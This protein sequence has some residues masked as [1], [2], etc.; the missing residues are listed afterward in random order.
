[1]LGHDIGHTPFG[2]SGE[3]AMDELM[4]AHGGFDH[5]QQALRI[6]EVLEHR[7]PRPSPG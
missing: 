6:L 2:H 4:H 7:Y 3:R 1:M 5:N